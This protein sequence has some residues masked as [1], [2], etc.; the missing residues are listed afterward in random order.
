MIKYWKRAFIISLA[1]AL[2]GFAAYGASIFDGLIPS[3]TTALE[4][5][6]MIA[7]INSEKWFIVAYRVGTKRK[8]TAANLNKF[9]EV[10]SLFDGTKTIAQ[11]I[12]L[13]PDLWAIPTPPEVNTLC[14][15]IDP[16][17]V[18]PYYTGV[19]PLYDGAAMAEGYLKDPTAPL[20]KK[21]IGTVLVKTPCGPNAGGIDGSTIYWW[22]TNLDGIQGVALCK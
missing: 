19:R 22:V 12:E 10:E 15:K 4:A 21:K 8:C 3:T 20:I 5:K 11:L 13:R 9:P 17:V 7:T 2:F 14:N 6:P 16:P 18:A 1:A